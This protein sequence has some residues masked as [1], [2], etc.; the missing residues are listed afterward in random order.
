MQV[1]SFVHSRIAKPDGKMTEQWQQYITQLEDQLQTNFSDEGYVLPQ[2]TE[3]TINVVLAPQAT[4]G[5]IVW[6]STINEARIF[7]ADGMFHTILT[8]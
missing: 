4:V 5:T 1:P 2:Q 7:K 6:D 3:D 8:S